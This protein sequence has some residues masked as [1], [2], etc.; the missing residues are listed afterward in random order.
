[1]AIKR[2]SEVIT[3]GDIKSWK[4][5]DVITITAGTGAG[6]SYFIKNILYKF[7][8]EKGKKILMLIH[9]INCV[10]QFKIEINKDGKQDIIHIDTYQKHEWKELNKLSTD[11]SEYE[12]I[13]CDE[14]HYF[15][16]DASFNY[17]TDIS[18][19]LILKQ[20]NA[21]KI[22]MSA[23]GDSVKRY[24][25]GKKKIDTIDYNLPIS[26]NHIK[27]VSFFNKD[28]TI[29]E[30]I[31]ECIEKGDQKA[32][33]FIESAEKAYNLYKKYKK[34]ALFNCG[35]SDKHY[36][37][38]DR[39]KIDSMLKNERF[40]ELFLITTTCMDAGVN[41]IDLDL[42]H[43]IADVKDIG[44]LI[45]CI[46]RKRIQGDDDYLNVYIKNITNNQLGG[47]KTQLQKKIEF[48]KYL[49]KNSDIDFVKEFPR[50][51]DYS[52]I[53][54]DV[55][56]DGKLK[57]V[58]NELMYFKNLEDITIYDHMIEMKNS[59]YGYAKCLTEKFGFKWN[60]IRVL[61]E[62]SSK[63]NLEEHLDKIGGKKLFK[64]EQ[65]EL[66][67][68]TNVKRNGKLRKSRESINS[69]FR[70][71]NVLYRIESNVDWDRKLPTGEK[72]K[73]YG[74]TYWIV[75]KLTA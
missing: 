24:I 62:K 21:I 6:K 31:K 13:V 7:A 40:E 67:I 58:V 73:N 42:K 30:L 69:S 25:S 48:A 43:I 2:V 23:T 15:M 26:Y 64:E 17:T 18:L 52:N 65:E 47:M 68:I 20:T 35:K 50:K 66:A 34:Y 72:N 59:K 16:S 57:K 14:F 74:K 12:Y 49:Y 70:E 61:E 44:V 32:I 71:D 22:F 75:Y 39:D 1:M 46:G 37:Y 41:I 55:I 8:K 3:I 10:E 11:L 29:E 51:Q 36:K 28:N 27:A 63:C 38:V 45:Q 9:R 33:F 53:I 60:S 54:Y 4:H 5:G 19:N 56:I